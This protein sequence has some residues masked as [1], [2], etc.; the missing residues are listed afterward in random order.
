MAN[1]GISH[2]WVAKLDM[3]TGKYKDGFRCGKAVN[4]SVTPNFNEGSMFADNQEQEHV[5]EFKNATVSLGVDRLPVVASKTMFGHDVTEDGEEINNVEDPSNY[6]GYGFI[7][8]ELVDS[9][10]RYRACIL[11]KV[12]FSEGEESFETKGDSIVFKSPTLS[13]IALAM[14]NG[15]WRVK[16]PYFATEKEADL[17]IQ[18]MLNVVETCA[19]PVA[20]IA[21][22]AY[23][24]TQN[25]ILSTVTP[26]AK[27]KYTTDGTTPSENNG[28]EYENPV[29]IAANTGLRAYA[30]KEG[31]EPS[32]LLT[33][34]YYINVSEP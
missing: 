11:L 13:G 17:W 24:E 16:S 25:V 30:F 21:G 34:E 4:T 6:V 8:A 7:T 26:G 23:T 27:I 22:G 14:E 5:K 28:I 32:D 18:K 1:F 3:T 9:K 33:V 15:D 10:K 29:S 2:P 19:V 12:L 20:S 31:M